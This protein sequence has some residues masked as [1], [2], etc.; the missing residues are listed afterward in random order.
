MDDLE[1]V[2][3]TDGTRLRV[4]RRGEGGS[5]RPVVL[6]HGLASNARLWDGVADRLAAAG[7]PS[8]A[9]DLRSHGRSER[10][11]GGHDTQQAAD[12]VREVAGLV[13][14]DRPV[15]V[16]QS[17]GG[18]VVVR[19]GAVASSDVSAVVAVDG[20]AIDLRTAFDGDWEAARRALTPPKLA[21]T[22]ASRMRQMIAAHHDDFAP[23]AIEAAMANFET[24]DDGTIAPWLPLEHHLAIVRSLWDG[25]PAADLR[26]AGVPTSLL[27]VRSK[28][29][30]APVGGWLDDVVGANARVELRWVEDR[31]HDVHAQ[32]PELVADHIRSVASRPEVRQEARR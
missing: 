11:A 1:L 8:I 21:G 18:S 31:V 10:T 4:L 22:A 28:G 3:L 2:T 29:G 6:V 23:W 26:A 14:F 20:G 27:L 16:G 24:R 15:V 12:D 25:D 9:V 30:S 32:D 17:W 13:G 7:H 5:G 19:L